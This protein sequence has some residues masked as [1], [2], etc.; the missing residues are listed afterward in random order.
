MTSSGHGEHHQPRF[1]PAAGDEAAPGIEAVVFDLDGTLADTMA[2]APQAYADTIRSLGGPTVSPDEVV[3]TWN[4]GST[5]VVLGHFLGRKMT[6]RDVDCFYSHFESFMALV[7]PF[8]GIPGMLSELSR[9]GYRTGVFT[10]ATRRA[11]AITLAGTELDR[12]GL[13]IVGGDEIA[14]PKPAP[15]GL[16]LTC[17]RLNVSPAAAAYVGDAETDLQCAVAAGSLGIHA[18]W[19]TAAR[20]T[21]PHLAAAHPGDVVGLV[22]AHHRQTRP[23]AASRSRSRLPVPWS[24]S[25][26]LFLAGFDVVR[27]ARYASA[28]TFQSVLRK[29]QSTQGAFRDAFG[30]ADRFLL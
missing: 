11:A 28:L 26:F 24:S 2:L 3:A 16:Q 12:F 22:A 17:R 30:P 29:G 5:P 27:F 15:E 19:G 13:T 25:P 20:A 23:D 7:R 4:I 9:A 18:R 1:P 10:H 6:S 14:E 8:P 21:T